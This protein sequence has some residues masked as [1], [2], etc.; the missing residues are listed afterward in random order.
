MLEQTEEVQSIKSKRCRRKKQ[1]DRSRLS[2]YQIMKKNGTIIA[3]KK[4]ELYEADVKDFLSK[5]QSG[6]IVIE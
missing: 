3:G 1:Y 6:E 4:F 2:G 5:L